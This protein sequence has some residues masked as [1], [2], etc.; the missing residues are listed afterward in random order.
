MLDIAREFEQRLGPSHVSTR[1]VR[2][3][4]ANAHSRLGEFSLARDAIALVLDSGTAQNPVAVWDI[5]LATGL[6]A[7]LRMYSGDA[8]GA[9]P[10]LRQQINDSPPNTLVTLSIR[11]N[12]AEALLRADM[13]SEALPELEQVLA[14]Q[15]NRLGQGHENVARTQVL[16]AVAN[17]RLAR[18]AEA[19]ALIEPAAAILLK[20]RGEHYYATLAARVYRAVMLRQSSSADSAELADRLVRELG[21]QAGAKQLADRIRTPE[22]YPDTGSLPVVF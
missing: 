18:H 6:S 13:T 5:N 20:E 10:L 2:L 12:Y 22:K 14:A 11:R 19:R 4:L 7:K 3:T 21:W 9:L 16:L 17:S 8:L 1:E 15:V